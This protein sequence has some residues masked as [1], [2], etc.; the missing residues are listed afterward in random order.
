MKVIKNISMQGLELSFA[1]AE[2]I[3]SVFL[4]PKKNIE[5]PDRWTSKVAENLV[6]R[7]MIKI[8]HLADPAPTEL[9]SSIKKIRKG[10]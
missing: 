5:I 7:R 10:K 1:T 4:A 8:T 2:G 9:A 3:R 6:H